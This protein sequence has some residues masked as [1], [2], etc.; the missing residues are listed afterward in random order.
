[1]GGMGENEIFSN[2]SPFLHMQGPFLPNLSEIGQ[3]VKKKSPRGGHGPPPW[4][5]R[6]TKFEKLKKTSR[7]N[8]SMNMY[9]KFCDDRTIFRHLK[10]RGTESGTYRQTDIHTEFFFIVVLGLWEVSKP[11]KKI[12][13]R[14]EKITDRIH[15]GIICPE[16]FG[17]I[18]NDF[19]FFR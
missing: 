10:I 3:L 18:K 15:Y 8:A 11:T 12:L 16:F 14:S 5:G 2:T 6:G 17:H 1:M 13:A 19:V 4:G 9:A 7:G